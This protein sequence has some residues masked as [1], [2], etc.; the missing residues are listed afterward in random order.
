[1]AYPIHRPLPYVDQS[2]EAEILGGI[3]SGPSCSYAKGG[4]I[5]LFNG[6]GVG[7]V[8]YHNGIN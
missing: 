7:K 1:M 4:K 3:S 8:I 6:A 2:T 5:G